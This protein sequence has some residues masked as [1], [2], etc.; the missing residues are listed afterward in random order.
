LRIERTLCVPD[1]KCT[2]AAEGASSVLVVVPLRPT[3]DPKQ[4]PILWLPASKG[5]SDVKGIEA[6]EG[7]EEPWEILRIV[8]LKH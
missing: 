8:L 3:S 7:M 4:N 5:L 1:A 2:L 6:F